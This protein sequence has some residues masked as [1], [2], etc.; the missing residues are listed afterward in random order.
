MHKRMIEVTSEL[1]G[2][3]A[4]IITAFLTKMTRAIDQIDEHALEESSARTE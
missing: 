1:S 3:E 4:S 2:E